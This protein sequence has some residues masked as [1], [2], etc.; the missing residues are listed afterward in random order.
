MGLWIA[1]GLL[2]AAGGRIA[3]ENCHDGGA[4]FTMVVPGLAKPADADGPET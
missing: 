4:R 1:K 2:A 3:A